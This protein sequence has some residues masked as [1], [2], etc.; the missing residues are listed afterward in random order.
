MDSFGSMQSMP[1][2]EAFIDDINN[3]DTDQGEALQ[4]SEEDIRKCYEVWLHGL[5]DRQVWRL[6]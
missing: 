5:N 3:H 2:E 1:D 6:W 4:L